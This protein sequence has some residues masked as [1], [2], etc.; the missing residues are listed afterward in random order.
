M[1]IRG[2]LILTIVCSSAGFLAGGWLGALAAIAAVSALDEWGVRDAMA[3]F[4]TGAPL[5]LGGAVV[6]LL[7]GRTFAIYCLPARCPVCA[8][9]TY[10]RAG[11]PI[12]YRCRAC[13]YVHQTQV[14]GGWVYWTGVA[15][16]K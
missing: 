10:Y 5:F 1:P 7:L 9:R 11:E 6:G 13:G 8:G 12:I 16:R 14:H 2:H 4:F 3:Y 15:R